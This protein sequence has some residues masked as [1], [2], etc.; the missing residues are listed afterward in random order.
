MCCIR[1]AV[2]LYRDR[3]FESLSLR[4][5]IL[6]R[7]EKQGA[8]KGVNPSPSALLFN[9]KDPLGLFFIYLKT[10]DNINKIMG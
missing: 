10:I 1:N 6:K 5:V 9:K 4:I 2:S 7:D 3:G 8:P